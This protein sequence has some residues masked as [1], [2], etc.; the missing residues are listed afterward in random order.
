MG[1]QGMTIGLSEYQETLRVEQL[2]WMLLLPYQRIF[3]TTSSYLAV[4]LEGKNTG[5]LLQSIL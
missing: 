2:P 3:L 4:R 5:G 1:H